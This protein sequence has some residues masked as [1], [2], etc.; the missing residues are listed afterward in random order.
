VRYPITSFFNF[1]AAF[2]PTYQEQMKLWKESG[3]V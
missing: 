3:E 1:E 2:P